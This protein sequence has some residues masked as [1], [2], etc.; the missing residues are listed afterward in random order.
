M[1]KKPKPKQP[2]QGG[3]RE[4]AGRK[5]K[6]NEETAT[7]AFRC[8]VSKVEELKLYVTAKLAEWSQGGI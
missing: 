7:V 5:Q 3:K 4:G 1:S 8:P 2:K 6:F